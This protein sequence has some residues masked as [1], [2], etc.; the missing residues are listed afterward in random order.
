MKIT[1]TYLMTFLYLLC[2]LGSGFAADMHEVHPYT[3]ESPVEILTDDVPK[4]Y[5][6]QQMNDLDCTNT[7]SSFPYTQGFEAPTQLWAESNDDDLDWTRNLGTTQSTSTG[8]TEA[9]SGFWYMYIEASGDG[10]GYPYKKA[11]LVSPCFDLTG[12]QTA[13]LSFR[14]HFHGTSTDIRLEVQISTDAGL[15]WQSTVWS[16][17][18]NLN[19]QWNLV[20]ID[21]NNYTNQ[22]ITLRFLGTTGE[23]WQGD[24]AID[25]I[26]LDAQ[27][28]AGC[29]PGTACNDNDACTINDIYDNNCN[30]KGTFKDEDDDG[31]CDANDTCPYIDDALIGTTCNDN[32][33]CT[34]G[35]IYDDACNC[36][37]TFQ[38]EDGDG[39]CDAEDVCAGIDDALIGM[40]CNDNDACT[41]NDVY[42]DACNC[43]GT[44]QDEDGDGVCDANDVCFG[45]DDGLIGTPC[46]DND[47]CT[48]GDIYDDNCNCK[49]VFQDTDG[50]GVCDANDECPTIDDALIG[51][52]CD[53][54]DNCTTGEKYDANCNCTGG[55][56]LDNNNNNICDIYEDCTGTL[57]EY[58]SFEIGTGNWTQYG[59]DDLDWTRHTGATPSGETGPNSATDGTWYMYI[60]ASGNNRGHPNKT[61]ILESDCYDLSNVTAASLEF[62]YHMYGEAETMNLN[63]QV[64]TDKGQTWSAVIWSKMGDQGNQ[65]NT[66]TLDLAPYIGQFIKIR[67]VGTTGLVWRGDMAI[68]AISVKS[69]TSCATEGQSC[70]DGN[71]CTTNDTYD[72]S[73]NCVG[74]FTD[75]DDD[76][77]CAARDPDDNDPC[78]PNPC[79][80]CGVYNNEN[81]ENDLG[82]WND[83]GGDAYRYSGYADSGE[84]S[85]RLRDNSGEASSIY[86]NTLDLSPYNSINVNFSYIAVDMETDED[87]FLEI[88]DDGGNTY[89]IVREWNADTEFV[90][91]T[92]YNESV[93]ID[94]MFSEKTVIRLRCDASANGD[95]VYIDDIVIEACGAPIP[96]P[97]LETPEPHLT[98]FPNPATQYIHIELHQSALSAEQQIDLTIYTSDGKQVYQ[99]RLTPANLSH[100][101]IEHL[102]ANQL[103]ILHLQT[104]SGQIFRT[105][106]L[107]L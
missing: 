79:S 77:V 69:S 11:G 35:D 13:K 92:R 61:A 75:A 24:M 81:F 105:K 59:D 78:I 102:S 94:G 40:A 58:Q 67:L 20:T 83:G 30:C 65:W 62:A 98:V 54:N 7:I 10:I 36:A 27:S 16:Q 29:T 34:T 107:K 28:G 96:D 45:T 76:G 100:I 21:L 104:D 44:F 90:N 15:T 12:R 51:T 6:E 74:T 91:D 32:D 2:G 9:Y 64:S 93:T 3:G 88:S 60:E 26:K 37:G 5:A 68:D 19:D 70:D 66:A 99:N 43:A 84:R 85:I 71:P 22:V 41:T 57:P 49:G 82:I 14:H 1:I 4:F 42:D 39:I 86:T 103:Y 95:E 87:F 63:I 48:E 56:L 23:T 97:K 38:D 25:E 80:A 53:D 55:T 8:P 73:C 46:D 31:V 47:P 18:G 52:T 17:T 101:N 106:F 89:S 33:P 72:T 50:D